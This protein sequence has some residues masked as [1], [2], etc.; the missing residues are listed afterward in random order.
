MLARLTQGM[1]S[2]LPSPHIHTYA[3]IAYTCLPHTLHAQAKQRAV[4]AGVVSAL[5]RVLAS[6][7]GD[8]SVLCVRAHMLISDL[9]RVEDMQVR[10]SRLLCAVTGKCGAVRCAWCAGWLCAMRAHIC[11]SDLLRMEDMQVR[12]I[13]LL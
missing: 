3:H 2:P 13:R 7:Q 9:L 4:D 12:C 8:G 5:A 10:L 1:T 6:D 11:S